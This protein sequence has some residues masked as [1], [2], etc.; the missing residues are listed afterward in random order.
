MKTLTIAIISHERPNN[1][2][3]MLDSLKT[4]AS[5]DK[6]DIIVSDN[7][8][9][10]SHKIENLCAQYKSI[11]LVRDKGC[12]QS[13][14]FLNAI[15]ACKSDFICLAHDDDYFYLEPKK[16]DLCLQILSCSNKRTLYYFNSICRICG[17]C[18]L[19]IFLL[20]HYVT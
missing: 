11:D 5:H 18:T 9:V 16:L 4:I 3:R 20:F 10:N 12:S 13:R 14:N 7:S 1:L 15:K 6:V 17:T 19:A 8:V 2:K